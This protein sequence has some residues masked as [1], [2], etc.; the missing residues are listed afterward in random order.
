VTDLYTHSTFIDPGT[1][2]EI[3]F[4]W[5]FEPKCK[6][7]TYEPLLFAELAVAQ[8]GGCGI[9]G[10]NGVL[11]IEDCSAGATPPVCEESA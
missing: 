7:W 10:A 1:G 6:V 4:E 2:L 3:D 8:P 9:A 5:Y 11:L